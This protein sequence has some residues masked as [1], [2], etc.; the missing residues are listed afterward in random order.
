MNLTPSPAS[1]IAGHGST[2]VVNLR[3]RRGDGPPRLGI[4][5]AHEKSRA[6]HVKH[7][8]PSR[9]IESATPTYCGHP[10]LE[11]FKHSSRKPT[12]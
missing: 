4:L 2:P 9:S 11:M 10:S 12:L 7:A 1:G 8:R 6:C 3:P 5:S